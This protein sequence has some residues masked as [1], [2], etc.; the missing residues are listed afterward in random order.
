MDVPPQPVLPSETTQPSR[1]TPTMQPQPRNIALSILKWLG[2]IAASL[3]T[4]ALGG[5]AGCLRGA[6]HGNALDRQAGTFGKGI[7]GSR[8]EITLAVMGFVGGG[9]AAVMVFVIVV[10]L[11]R[12]T[13][14]HQRESRS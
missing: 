3:V 2:Y 11:V 8:N 5:F 13:V 4:F 10:V 9:L 1:T 7:E 14:K 6:E 12:K